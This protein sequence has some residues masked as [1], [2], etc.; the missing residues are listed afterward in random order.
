MIE[1]GEYKVVTRGGSEVKII[2]WDANRSAP[3]VGLVK[4]ADGEDMLADFYSDGKRDMRPEI[5]HEWDL[6]ISVPGTDLTEFEWCFLNEIQDIHGAVVPVDITLL[7]ESCNKL[8]SIAEKDIPKWK[9]CEGDIP[10]SLV[11]ELDV[12]GDYHYSLL[13]G[14]LGPCREYIELSLIDKLPRLVQ[15]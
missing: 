12:N 6:F 14:H 7:K 15:E 3:I 5:T 11:R 2:Y 13:S 10:N 9:S 1:S 4:R 8:R